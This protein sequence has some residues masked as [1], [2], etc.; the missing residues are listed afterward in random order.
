[1]PEFV[2]HARQAKLKADVAGDGELRAAGF[3]AAEQV[4]HGLDGVVLVV[5]V[6]LEVEF[7]GSKELGVRSYTARGLGCRLKRP[8]WLPRIVTH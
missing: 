6:G 2:L 5:E 4:A 1:M 8:G 3:L 7:H